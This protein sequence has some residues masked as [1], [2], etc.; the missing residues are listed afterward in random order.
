MNLEGDSLTSLTASFTV[1]ERMA[2]VCV[3]RFIRIHLLT[4]CCAWLLGVGLIESL[5]SERLVP[6]GK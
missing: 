1:V 5:P 6:T 3:Y 4:T 2:P